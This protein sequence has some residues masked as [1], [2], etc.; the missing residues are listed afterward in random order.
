MYNVSKNHP[1]LKQLILP[2]YSL[3]KVFHIHPVNSYSFAGTTLCDELEA[4]NQDPGF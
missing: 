4:L 1:L 3:A 2:W